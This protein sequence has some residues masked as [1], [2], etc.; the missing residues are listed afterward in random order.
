MSF[1]KL[2]KV[3]KIYKVAGQDF[4]ALNNVSFNIEEAKFTV[5]VG[6]SGAGKSTLLNI[7]GGM[8][9]LSSGEYFIDS[10]CISNKK[11]KELTKFRLN[12][13]GFVFQ[14]YNL[15]PNLTVLENIM[16]AHP[17]V[18]KNDALN[19]LK[20]VGLLDKK[21]NFLEELSGGEQQRVAI[22]RA[23]VKNPKLLLC[24]EPTG[25][26]D[27]KTGR[28]IISIL[29]DMANIKHKNVIVVTHNSL[30]KEIAD[31]VIELKD[32]KILNK[33]DNLNP[34]MIS[35]ITW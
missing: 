26:L 5:I 15:M 17:S 8:D 33:Y 27:S 31:V 13:I 29:Y 14:H 35:E 25:A 11:E 3:S 1:I 21:D 4:Y 7:L 12:D 22:A 18:I 9:S 16:L 28:D 10:E 20:E 2:E 24:D 6:S 30:F 32:G 19:I 23:V 34:K